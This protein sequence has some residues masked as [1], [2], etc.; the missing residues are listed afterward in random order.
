MQQSIS[1]LIV[2]AVAGTLV[3]LVIGVISMLRPGR[4][5]TK[6]SQN[7]M[8]FRIL[9]QVAAVVFLAIAFLMSQ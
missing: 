3:V 1:W 9:F 4:F 6:H 8:R 7:L 5:T 2:L